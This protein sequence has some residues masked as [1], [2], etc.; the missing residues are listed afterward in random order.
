MKKILLSILAVLSSVCSFSQGCDLPIS[1]AYSTEAE[2][3]P[4]A[5]QSYMTNKLRQVLTANGVTGDMDFSQFALVPHYDVV[6][7]HVIA[8]PPTKLVYNISFTFT[9]VNTQDNTNMATM[10][11]DVDAVG[12]NENKAF[13]SGIG[14][15]ANNSPKIEN[16]ISNTRKKIIAYYNRNYQH[17]MMKAK[18]LAGMNR[19]EEA[20]YY[21]MSIP[22]CCSGYSAAMK[23][24]L[25]IYQKN[26]NREGEKMLMQARAIWASGNSDESAAAAAAVLMGIDPSANCYGQAK[27][28]LNEIKAKASKNQPWN[29]ELKKYSDS[30][31]IE[32]QKISAARA[33]G[34]AYGKGQKNQTTNLMFVR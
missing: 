25:P 8:G 21:V 16:F 11:M 17:L 30:V 19:Y 32:Q 18:V 7:K 26:V 14:R 27:V 5:S 10:A 23:V 29:F 33:I 15:I 22:E 9:V 1:I 12:E 3:M 13:I 20:L 6:D 24:A 2:N 34:V 28:L 31:S 4:D